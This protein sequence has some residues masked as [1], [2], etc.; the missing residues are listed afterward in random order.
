MGMDQSR[1]DGQIGAEGTDESNDEIQ[2]YVKNRAIN[3]YIQ[4]L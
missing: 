4:S 3:L 2:R 1:A